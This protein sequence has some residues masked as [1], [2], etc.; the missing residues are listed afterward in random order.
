MR[1]SIYTVKS[2]VATTLPWELSLF[3]PLG[4]F[5]IFLTRSLG[6]VAVGGLIVVPISTVAVPAAARQAIRW[7]S[8]LVP[9]LR[10]W[11]GL[12]LLVLLSGL[13]FRVRETG[14]I[15][16]DA[17]DAWAVYRIAVMGLVVAILAVRLV[18]RKTPWLNSLFRGSVGATA[19]Y[20]IICLT[21]TI[22]SV[23]PGWTLYKSAEYLAELAV[24]AAILAEIRS[25]KEYGT[26]LDWTWLLYGLL[27]ASVWLS[28]A[29]FP[30]RAWA[31]IGGAIGIRLSGAMPAMSDNLVG[32]IGAILGIISICRLL[33]RRSEKSLWSLVLVVSLITMVFAQTRSAIA[34]FLFGL[35]V[36]LVFARRI[37]LAF[38]TFGAAIPFA[39]DKF[40]DVLWAYT[41]RG[42]TLEG[43]EHASSRVDW[44]QVGWKMFIDQPWGYGA[45][46]GGRFAV[47]EQLGGIS[48]MHSTY[49]EIIVGTGI[50]GLLPVVLALGATWWVLMRAC[51]Q[52]WR[53]PLLDQRLAV[54]VAGVLAVLTVRSVFSV[55]F[56]WHPAIEFL[57]VLG[58]GE[59]LR[60][61]CFVTHT[62][63]PNTGLSSSIIPSVHGGLR[64]V[65][66][67]DY[68]ARSLP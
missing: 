10:W 38:L 65:G 41:L 15:R 46:A 26:L 40:G 2:S 54:E 59:M 52:P 34:G 56:V 30:G 18:L 20:C 27:L 21:S 5:L 1:Q 23:Y 57:A 35:F 49:M 22:W 13:V 42:D 39:I 4:A 64:A 66:V 37:R 36:V 7:I 60:R 3:V 55:K 45:Y 11:H 43:F 44:W 62:S 33:F 58:Y 14:E 67:G 8:K 63:R 25:P 6:L 28:S 16:E 32:E 31:H 51:R 12:W 9:Q 24:L 50:V 29:I 48:N 19:I 47:L 68:C 53:F 17:L 61:S